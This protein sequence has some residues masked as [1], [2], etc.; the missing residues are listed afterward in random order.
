MPDVELVFCPPIAIFHH[1]FNLSKEKFMY[2]Y[3]LLLTQPW[4][5]FKKQINIRMKNM[6]QNYLLFGQSNPIS[7]MEKK[8]LRFESLSNW[9]NIVT[10]TVELVMSHPCDTGKV[11]F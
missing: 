7:I 4:E 8:N 1:L 6:F 10:Y 5:Y 11:A 9:T 3:Y 2:N